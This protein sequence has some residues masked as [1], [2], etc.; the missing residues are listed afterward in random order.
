MAGDASVR[1]MHMLNRI[2]SASG[3]DAQLQ[4]AVGDLQR[5][6]LLASAAS[7]STVN[8]STANATA[9]TTAN[10]PG[11]DTLRGRAPSPPLS[12]SRRRSMSRTAARTSK[13]FAADNAPPPPSTIDTTAAVRQRARDRLRNK[14]FSAKGDSPDHSDASLEGAITSAYDDRLREI[15]LEAVAARKPT[16][17]FNDPMPSAVH[18]DAEEMPYVNPRISQ[19]KRSSTRRRSTLTTNIMSDPM[20][21][22]VANDP[23]RISMEPEAED[24]LPYVAPVRSPSIS[25]QRKRSSVLQQAISQ[26]AHRL[27]KVLLD[28]ETTKSTSSTT[29]N[30]QEFV[31]LNDE[32]YVRPTTITPRTASHASI[33]ILR[34]K[35]NQ[36]DLSNLLGPDVASVPV[37]D[38]IDAVAEEVSLVGRVDPETGSYLNTS[39]SD[40]VISA[41]GIYKT[42]IP[43]HQQQPNAYS[44]H[45]PHL[46]EISRAASSPHIRTTPRSFSPPATNQRQTSPT[47]SLQSLLESNS[48]TS[49][50]KRFSSTPS[51]SPSTAS[52]IHPTKSLPRPPKRNTHT[53]PP[54]ASDVF[55]DPT[56]PLTTTSTNHPSSPLSAST[57]TFDYP[58]HR[59]PSNPS[60]ANDQATPP[61]PRMR[62]ESSIGIV[63][64]AALSGAASALSYLS[65]A[66]SNYVATSSTS[67]PTSTTT[68]TTTTNA[69]ST[70]ASPSHFFI[71]NR[72]EEEMDPVVGGG[73]GA[74]S[75]T[76]SSLPKIKSPA[77][78]QGTLASAYAYFT[79]SS[80]VAVTPK[81]V[82]EPAKLYGGGRMGTAAERK[83]GFAYGLGGSEAVVVVAGSAADVGS[84]GG[85]GGG[86]GLTSVVEEWWKK[87]FAGVVGG[88]G[89]EAGSRSGSVKKKED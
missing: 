76:D 87:G 15:V 80:A 58:P 21:S 64:G 12:P 38:L 39:T 6:A 75:K 50:N 55:S 56:A 57:T 35:S 84:G 51:S 66:A 24:E 25:A 74:A 37:Q 17:E 33:S 85:G 32:P 19:M 4:Q 31:S 34:R 77:P 79:A 81:P 69:S 36:L 23:T 7:A 70:A 78:A 1:Q 22:A 67:S 60:S 73:G 65:K 62:R 18:D 9:T 8:A 71:A 43:K 86:G 20:P 16:A 53:T 72:S 30:D 27:S 28:H 5:E 11:T 26:P 10:T 46:R 89:G 41:T 47:N 29:L 13:L 42:E 3:W 48:A 49:P 61:P 88:G 54:R 40:F 63:A 14:S 52:M 44:P 83:A 68:T 2:A 45:P 82:V 59:Y